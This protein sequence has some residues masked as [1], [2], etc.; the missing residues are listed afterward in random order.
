MFAFIIGFMGFMVMFLYSAISLSSVKRTPKACSPI[1]SSVVM[2]VMLT[3]KA[4]GY[5][6]NNMIYNELCFV[7]I[8]AFEFQ[9]MLICRMDL[10]V[11]NILLCTFVAIVLSGWRLLMFFM[12]FPIYIAIVLELANIAF[13]IDFLL[14]HTQVYNRNL[15]YLFRCIALLS[16][17]CV[18]ND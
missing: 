14:N 4:Y 8:I 9:E 7:C 11:K 15:Q 17:L 3:L 18:N 10:F 6:L 1:I 13:C 2:I 5:G 12:N 16:S